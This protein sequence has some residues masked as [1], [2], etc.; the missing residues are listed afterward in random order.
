LY[1]Q[2]AS[3]SYQDK[4]ASF[5]RSYISTLKER[6][7]FCRD[8]KVKEAVEVLQVLEKLHIHVDLQRFL[9][10]MHICG[11]AKSCTQTCFATFASSYGYG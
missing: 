2:R 10:L 6:D 5:G 7:S 1:N 4:H 8:G 3:G 9:Q 11:K